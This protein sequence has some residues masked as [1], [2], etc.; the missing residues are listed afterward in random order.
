[1]STF[2]SFPHSHGKQDGQNTKTDESDHRNVRMVKHGGCSRKANS[3]TSNLMLKSEEKAVRRKSA[4]RS[5]ANFQQS[6]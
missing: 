4:R 3:P 2:T 5:Q 1:V 6:F